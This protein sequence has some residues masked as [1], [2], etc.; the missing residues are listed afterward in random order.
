MTADHLPLTGG[1]IQTRTVVRKLVTVAP[2]IEIKLGKFGASG[3]NFQQLPADTQGT[4][5]LPAKKKVMH[6]SDASKSPSKE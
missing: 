6:Q 2:P 1:F 5:C 3:A 4:Y